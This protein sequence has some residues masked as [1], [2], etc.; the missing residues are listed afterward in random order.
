MKQRSSQK[1]D[2]REIELGK[3]IIVGGSK[4]TSSLRKCYANNNAKPQL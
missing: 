2:K 1:A 3:V 4:F